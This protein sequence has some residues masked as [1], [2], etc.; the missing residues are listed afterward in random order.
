MVCL[1]II[2][3]LLSF[4]SYSHD[5]IRI[6][7]PDYEGHPA[8]E[9]F[10]DLLKLIGEKTKDEYG[11]LSITIIDQNI[12]QG[13]S[14]YE[15]EQNRTIDL[16]WFGTNYERERKLRPIRIPLF[17][18]LLGYR[19]LII[20]EDNIEVFDSIQTIE[21]LKNLIAI[22]GTH[23]PDSD[24]LESQGFLVNRTSEYELM[25]RILQAKRVDYF[26]RSITE[27]YAE[28]NELNLDGLIVYDNIIISYPFAMY[29]FVNKNDYKLAE[30]LEKG[31]LKAIDDGS[32]L[33]LLK[34]H[35]AT[36]DAFPLEKYKDAHIFPVENRYLPNINFQYIENFK[37]KI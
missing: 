6:R 2:F 24:I 28:I 4:F 27:A 14:I 30:R 3:L 23:W 33:K 12:T 22:Q 34:N 8:H 19:T 36:R 17:A 20:H 31:L 11:T 16:D 29:F 1:Y 5:D 10:V 18:G 21:D 7:K 15:L 37:M 13:R 32:F 9:Y 26:P 35:K 25:F